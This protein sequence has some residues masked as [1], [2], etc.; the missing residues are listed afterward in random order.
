MHY[1]NIIEKIIHNAGK[2]NYE[3]WIKEC[4]EQIFN[5]YYC[6]GK[7]IDTNNE[8]NKTLFEKEV[9]YKMYQFHLQMNGKYTKEQLKYN[10]ENATYSIKWIEA[11]IKFITDPLAIEVFK[12]THGG[13]EDE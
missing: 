7:I 9:N 3:K 1:D 4:S 13:D 12:A 11:S 2:S 6:M 5:Y 10:M 8:I